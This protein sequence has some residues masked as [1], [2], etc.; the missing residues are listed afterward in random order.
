MPLAHLNTGATLYYDDTGG[1]DKPIVILVHGLLGT[2][3]L[4]FPQVTAWLAPNYRVIGPTMRGYGQ[5]YPK[6]RTFTPDF[7]KRDTLDVLALMD[8][9]GIEQAH[10]MG[11]SDGGEVAIIAGGTQPSRFKSVTAWGA[12]GYFGPDMRPVAQR[13]YPGDW[14]TDDEMTLHGIPNREAFVLAWI[15]SVKA[16][17][18]AGGDVSLSLAPHISAPLLLMLGDQDTLNPEAYG[19]NLVNQAPNGQLR[20]FQCAHPV[21]DQAWDEFQ[22]VVGAFLASSS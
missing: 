18:D 19:R 11:Y 14:I 21:H 12:V 17:I 5:S 10:I 8:V 6:P 2:A 22:S 3:A 15:N 13:M 20:M 9:I 4:H 7:Y 16:M 1:D